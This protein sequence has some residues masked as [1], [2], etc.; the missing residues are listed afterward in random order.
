MKTFIFVCS[1]RKKGN[2]LIV[3]GKIQGLLNKDLFT[4]NLG[5]I[6]FADSDHADLNND[7]KSISELTEMVQKLSGNVIETTAG[8]II[9]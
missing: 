4:N 5:S 1:P 7:V 3:P 9:K 6:H 2:F 8:R